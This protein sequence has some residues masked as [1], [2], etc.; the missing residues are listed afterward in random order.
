MLYS[1]RHHLL[2]YDSCSYQTK[3]Y[4]DK[5]V[6]SQQYLILTSHAVGFYSLCCFLSAAGKEWQTDFSEVEGISAWIFYF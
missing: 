1:K 2:N 6:Y 5:A 4:I 3:Q